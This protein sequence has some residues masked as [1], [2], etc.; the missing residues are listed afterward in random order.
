M[1]APRAPLQVVDALDHPVFRDHPAVA[2]SA[3]RSHLGLPLIDEDGYVLGSL[4]GL[5]DEPCE[6]TRGST[7]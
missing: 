6:F 4:G 2:A 7:R 1:V 3:I 5:D